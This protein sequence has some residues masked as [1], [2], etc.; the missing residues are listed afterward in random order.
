MPP[1]D[2]TQRTEGGSIVGAEHSAQGHVLLV[3]NPVPHQASDVEG[4]NHNVMPWINLSAGYNP[5]SRCLQTVIW[6]VLQPFATLILD[7]AFSEKGANT[8]D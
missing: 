6:F 8:L 1:E 2:L 5:T 4:F 3:W 7:E